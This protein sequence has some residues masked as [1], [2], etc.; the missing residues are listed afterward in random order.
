MPRIFFVQYGL[1]NIYGK[2]EIQDQ[3]LTFNKST[4]LTVW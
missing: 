4:F 3:D 1:V 2:N